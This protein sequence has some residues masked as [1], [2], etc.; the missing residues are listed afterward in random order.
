MGCI[1]AI[2]RWL[3]LDWEAIHHRQMH[4]ADLI[5]KPLEKVNGLTLYTERSDYSPAVRVRMKVDAA[6][7]PRDAYQINTAIGKGNPVIKTD[8]Y[9]VNVGD[10]IFDLSYVDEDDARCIANAVLDCI[11]GVGEEARTVKPT[12]LTR[13]DL[14]YN[15]MR[16][17]LR[18]NPR[19]VE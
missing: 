4:L 5:I 13:Q 14:L 6:V 12:H 2:K 10:I 3:S 7:C 15:T 11:S 19:E 9:F 1:A 8:D 16:L 18:G 17:W